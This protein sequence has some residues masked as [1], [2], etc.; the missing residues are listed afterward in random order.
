MITTSVTFDQPT[1]TL[2]RELDP[3]VQR[4]RAFFALLN[5][6]P[7][8]PLEPPCSRRGAHGPPK[9]AYLKALLVKVYEGKDSIPKLRA[10]LLEHPLLILEVGF[11]PKLDPSRPYGFDIESTLRHQNAGCAINNSI[12]IIDCCKTSCITRSKTSKPRSRA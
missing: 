3:V 7:F 12:S 10:F 1:L 5:W 8:L 11:V 4:Y 2:M 9:T 6:T